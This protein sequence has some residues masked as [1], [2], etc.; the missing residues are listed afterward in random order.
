[1]K[2]CLLPC[3]EDAYFGLFEAAADTPSSRPPRRYWTCS[4]TSRTSRRGPSSWSTSSMRATGSPATSSPTGDDLCRPLRPGRDLRLGQGLDD[5]T[6]AIEE[7]VDL[8]VL[9]DINQPLQGVVEQAGVLVQAAEHT[10]GGMRGLR[11]PGPSAWTSTRW[12]RDA[13]SGR[14]SP[15]SPSGGRAV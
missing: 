13:G 9:H 4:A 14:G 11:Q 5:V 8:L 15:A 3:Q 7:V 12:P 6:D 10:A 1:M 2:L